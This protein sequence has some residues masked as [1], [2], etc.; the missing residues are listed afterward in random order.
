MAGQLRWV[1]VL[2]LSD[3][4]LSNPGLVM[5][6]EEGVVADR[7]KREV[8]EELERWRSTL[9]SERVR[10][11]SDGIEEIEMEEVEVRERREVAAE[12]GKRINIKSNDAIAPMVSQLQ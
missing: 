6:R 11:R 3:T 10:G 1:L 8:S 12:S 7:E 4:V 9:W 5:V 2:L